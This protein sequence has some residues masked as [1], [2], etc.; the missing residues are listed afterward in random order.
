LLPRH[1]GDEPAVVFQVLFF[2]Q[3]AEDL[4]R[5][6][7]LEPLQAKALRRGKRI[8]HSL[9]Q[10]VQ[11]V[12]EIAADADQDFD[13]QRLHLGEPL[14]ERPYKRL[15][16][17][18]TFAVDEELLELIEEEHDWR[19]ILRGG[20]SKQALKIGPVGRAV[21]ERQMFEAGSFDR[22]ERVEVAE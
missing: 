18:F 12:E 7:R 10:L 6:I 4:G 13:R 1:F 21:G 15:A 19:S 2:G 9:L 17:F 14:G 5:L 8:S 20:C 3:E 11:T 16:V 22:L